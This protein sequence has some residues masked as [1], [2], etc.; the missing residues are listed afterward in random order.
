MLITISFSRTS[1]NLV[2]SDDDSTQVPC[3]GAD[4]DT[5]SDA[6]DM[7]DSVFQALPCNK[8]NHSPNLTG[9]NKNKTETSVRRRNTYEVENTV[10]QYLKRMTNS[11]TKVEK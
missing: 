4:D 6:D 9:Q 5:F 1:G 8:M 7:E 3:T 11:P 10:C 2:T